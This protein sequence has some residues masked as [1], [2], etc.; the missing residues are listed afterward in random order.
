MIKAIHFKNYKA[1][2][3]TTLPLG[4]LTVL[5]GPNGSGKSTALEAIAEPRMNTKSLSVGAEPAR[6]TEI[7]IEAEWDGPVASAKTRRT[8]VVGPNI[9]SMAHLNRGG[10]MLP[11]EQQALLN[12][13][14]G[15]SRIYSFEAERIA[16]AVGLAPDVQLHRDG[17]GLAGVLDRLR[18][19]HPERFEAL[20]EELARW[21]PEFDR[22]LFDTPAK[23]QRAIK[24]RLRDSQAAI[25]AGDVSHG[26][27]L[28]L[29]LLT[30]AYLPDP[31]PIVGLE[32][33]DR[34]LHPRL[35]RDVQDALHRL[36]F[37]ESCG[38]TRQPVQVVV[39]THNPYFLDLFKDHP[40]EI[41][42]ANKLDDN[43][44]F[45][46]LS[47]MP[48]YQEIVAES[49]ASLG[50]IWFTGILGGVPANR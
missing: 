25:P 19:T 26:T 35:M 11:N 9:S 18:D 21:L 13:I 30:L 31:P 41:V 23:G 47:D 48:N 42:I 29:A 24:L 1:L 32:E 33:P 40:E 46:R 17:A 36:A 4:R 8:F 15:G 27:L 39:T 22:I 16:Q 45:Q 38:E 3:D 10:N 28:A 5:I 50:E 43:V 44:Q 7:A 49:D 2:R 14:L 6:G 12:V 20:N 37:P 34:G